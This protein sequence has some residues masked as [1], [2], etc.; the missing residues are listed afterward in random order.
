MNQNNDCLML[1]Q[2]IE[3][4]LS[5]KALQDIEFYNKIFANITLPKNNI[6]LGNN[7]ALDDNFTRIKWSELE[8]ILESTHP[9]Y[10]ICMPDSMPQFINYSGSDSGLKVMN[11]VGI[12]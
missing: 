12:G 9:K 11:N 6:I 2:N 8:L 1:L 5:R 10:L 3:D 7:T 4:A